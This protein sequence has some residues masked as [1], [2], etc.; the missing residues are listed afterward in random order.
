MMEI[1]GDSGRPSEDDSA[2]T[3]RVMTWLN[4][5]VLKWLA[6][7]DMNEFKDAFMRANINGQKL[8]SLLAV[9]LLRIGI[10]VLF[11][12]DRWNIRPIFLG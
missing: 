9:D 2:Q 6:Q 5:D 7:S 12:L 1:L 3:K 4:S 10:V 11:V 8:L